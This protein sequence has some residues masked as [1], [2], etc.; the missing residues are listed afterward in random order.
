MR[1]RKA[2]ILIVDDHPIVREGLVALLSRQPDFEVVGEAAGAA[3]AL[4]MVKER[5]PNVVT[6]DIALADGSGLD[7]IRRIAELDSEARML[8][9]SLHDESVYAERALRAG[10]V[11]Y[12]NKQDATQTI[13][14]AIQ[15]VLSGRTYLSEG[16]H[17]LLVQRFTTGRK[18]SNATGVER[19]SDRELEIYELIGAGRTTTEI[20]QL[21]HIGEKTVDTH[22]RRMKEKL[23]VVNNSQLASDATRWLMEHQ[24]SCG[25]SCQG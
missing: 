3:D 24:K 12:V 16:M 23:G 1:A 4:R 2:R 7:L 10:A 22:R 18:K 8:V 11:G 13:V 5:H 19:L 21:L 9:C 17:Q 6:V 15:D 20:S 25:S 14:Q